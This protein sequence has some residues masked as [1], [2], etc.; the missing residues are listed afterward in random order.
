M[1]AES[2]NH[3][4]EHCNV[5]QM[6]RRVDQSEAVQMMLDAVITQQLV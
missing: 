3:E 4:T 1:G 2:A 6:Q 5:V